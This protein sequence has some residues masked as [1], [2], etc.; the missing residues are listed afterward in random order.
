MRLS[1]WRVC[2]HLTDGVSV[3]VCPVTFSGLFKHQILLHALSAATLARWLRLSAIFIS[4]VFPV[5]I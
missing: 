2:G 3:F 1:C 5:Y 4:L